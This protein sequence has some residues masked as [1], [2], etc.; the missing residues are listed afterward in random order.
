[1]FL[2]SKKIIAI[3]VLLLMV[4][5]T[6]ASASGAISVGI[7]KGDWIEYNV[8]YTGTPPADHVANWARIE[9]LDIQGTQIS[10]NVTTTA[11][12]GTS[13]SQTNTLDLEAGDLGDDFIIP[14]NLKDGD[15][16]FDARDGNITIGSAETRTYA[17]A[18]RVVVVG[19]MREATDYWDQS[20]GVLL[21]GITTST[22]YAMTTKVDKT[23]LWE[24]Q[25]AGIDQTILIAAVLV[26]ILVVVAVAVVLVVRRRKK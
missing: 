3:I 21:E 1:V 24:A 19:Q 14:A 15:V 23:N 18:N 4:L 9:V 5:S 12:N 6:A 22:D 16:F 7:K 17:S 13:S 8:T 26:V 2:V 20:T 25:Q 11:P 10:V